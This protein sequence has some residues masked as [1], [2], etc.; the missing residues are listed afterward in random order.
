[1]YTLLDE[2]SMKKNWKTYLDV[3]QGV[4]KNLKITYFRGRQLLEGSVLLRRYCYLFFFELSVL[5]VC[6]SSEIFL[7]LDIDKVKQFPK[8]TVAL[9]LK[10]NL[11]YVCLIGSILVIPPAFARCF[12]L[13]VRIICHFNIINWMQFTLTW[14]MSTNTLDVVECRLDTCSV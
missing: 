12:L 13:N 5:S 7:Y 6:Q 14:H 4:Y 9:K 10:K 2:H 11:V 3:H 1:M 8:L